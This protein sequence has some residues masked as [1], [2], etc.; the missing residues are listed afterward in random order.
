[1]NFIFDYDKK[2]SLTEKTKHACRRENK[3]QCVAKLTH[4]TTAT[5]RDRT[6]E[7]IRC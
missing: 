1:M 6:G 5:I 4:N 7:Q 2:I 3:K